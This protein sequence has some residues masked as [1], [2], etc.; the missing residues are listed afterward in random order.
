MSNRIAEIGVVVRRLELGL[1]FLA[2]DSTMNLRIGEE[3][4]ESWSVGFLGTARGCLDSSAP[5]L[6]L[7]H[8]V[9]RAR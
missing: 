9:S 5:T 8:A 3:Y 1:P 6:R 7:Y 4:T 2:G